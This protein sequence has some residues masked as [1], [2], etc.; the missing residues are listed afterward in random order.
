MID[1]IKWICLI[2]ILGFIGFKLDTICKYMSTFVD[3]LTKTE[4]IELVDEIEKSSKEE[5]K[6]VEGRREEET[7]DDKKE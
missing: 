1:L 6:D 7:R 5:E 3:I 2:V 4:V